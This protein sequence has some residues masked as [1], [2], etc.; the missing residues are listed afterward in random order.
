MFRSKILKAIALGLCMS[1]LYTGAAYAQSGGGTTSFEGKTDVDNALFEKQSEID[2][3]LF[4]ENIKELEAKGIKVVYT[5]VA[6]DYIEIGV[7]SLKDEQADFIYELIGKDQV[8]LVSAEEIQMYTTMELEPAIAP[9]E[10]LIDRGDVPVT[11][12][13]E[14][15]KD[16]PV[17]ATD[18]NIAESTADDGRVYKGSDT[19]ATDDG[20]MLENPDVIF[21]TTADGVAAPGQEAELVYATGASGEVLTGGTENQKAGL[22]TPVIILLIAGGALVIGG[23]AVVLGKK[24]M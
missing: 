12:K 1:V 21:Y 24:R 7:A 14:L 22:S 3:I 23:G 20:D 16:M 9:D 8:K 19:V 2:R 11:D 15:Y 18:G 10:A 6:G 13:A 5:G 17:A 4:K